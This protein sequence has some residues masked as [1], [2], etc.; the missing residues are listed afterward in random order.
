MTSGIR[1][2]L[3]SEAMGEV[4]ARGLLPLGYYPQG[5]PMYLQLSWKGASCRHPHLLRSDRAVG[6]LNPP[7]K[8]SGTRLYV[9]LYGYRLTNY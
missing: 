6:S 5:H 8:S 7:L 4:E 9:Y 1:R 2:N 3:R